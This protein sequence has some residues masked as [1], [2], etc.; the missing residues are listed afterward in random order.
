MIRI[1]ST[2]LQHQ[3]AVRAWS[4]EKAAREAGVSVPTISR[5]MRGVPVRGLT[6][7]QLVQ[8]FAVIRRCPSSSTWCKPGTRGRR[9]RAERPAGSRPQTWVR[10]ALSA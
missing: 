6:A 1:S 7:L 8:A 10:P 9:A 4:M 5:A 3:V 2:E